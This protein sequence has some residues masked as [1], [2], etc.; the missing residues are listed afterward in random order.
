MFSTKIRS[1]IIALSAV[2]AVL[3]SSAVASAAIPVHQLSTVATTVV[4]PPTVSYHY[5][6]PLDPHKVGAGGNGGSNGWC[7][8]MAGFYNKDLESADNAET[9]GDQETFAAFS[10]RAE[11]DLKAIEDH[12]LIV[13]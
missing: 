2:G 10:G 9:A 1:T 4:A 11:E 5:L 3:A 6:S 12:C 7:E 8:D 13:D